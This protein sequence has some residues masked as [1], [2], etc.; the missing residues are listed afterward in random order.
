MREHRVTS[1]QMALMG[2]TRGMLGFGAG[3]LLADRLGRS[4]RKTLGWPLM[5]IG[6]ASTIPLGFWLFRNKNHRPKPG[7]SEVATMMAD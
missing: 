6:A 1:P 4:R 5:L 7:R 2:A 3:L